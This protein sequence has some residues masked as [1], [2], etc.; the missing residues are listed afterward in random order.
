MAASAR[1]RGNELYARNDHQQAVNLY[2]EAINLYPKDDKDLA[3]AYSNRAACY[4]KMVKER[5]KYFND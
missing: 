2:T 1:A 4:L 5:V 3:L